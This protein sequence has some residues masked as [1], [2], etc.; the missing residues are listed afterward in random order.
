VCS[1]SDGVEPEALAWSRLEVM[2]RSRR[3]RARGRAGDGCVVEVEQ[4]FA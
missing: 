3:Q 2:Q 4:Q 1:F